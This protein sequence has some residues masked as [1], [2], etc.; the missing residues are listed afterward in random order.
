MFDCETLRARLD[1]RKDIDDKADEVER[2]DCD[3]TDA[4][5]KIRRCEAL[6][7]VRCYFYLESVLTASTWSRL[8]AK[9]NDLTTTAES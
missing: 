6:R 9:S 4:L 2:E 8:E 7:S 5:D 1:R 3:K